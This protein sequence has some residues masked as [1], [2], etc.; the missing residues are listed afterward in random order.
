MVPWGIFD[1]VRPTDFELIGKV[2]TLVEGCWRKS[3]GIDFRVLSE[4]ALAGLTL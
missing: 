3:R 4:F 1:V 2:D